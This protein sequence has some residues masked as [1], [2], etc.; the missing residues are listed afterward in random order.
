MGGE[1]AGGARSPLPPF[2]SAG[3]VHTV[4]TTGQARVTHS[5]FLQPGS[6]YARMSA[7]IRLKVT[8]YI[9]KSWPLRV[10]NFQ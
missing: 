6:D 4:W 3:K 7:H 10:Q 8:N 2:H 9:H 1:K 5:E